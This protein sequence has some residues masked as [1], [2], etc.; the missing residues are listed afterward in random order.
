MIGIKNL[1]PS[2]AASKKRCGVAKITHV[3][4]VP[5]RYTRDTPLFSPSQKLR[6][7]VLVR[8]AGRAY[9]TVICG[10]DGINRLHYGGQVKGDSLL[11][12]FDLLELDGRDLRRE[13]IEL[14]KAIQAG[15]PAPQARLSFSPS[16]PMER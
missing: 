6:P 1:C 16:R 3:V 4:Q 9:S 13:A 7:K 10:D 14:R 8:T 11:Y 15:L 5:P 2:V 12:A